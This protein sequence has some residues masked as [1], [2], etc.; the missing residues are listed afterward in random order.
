VAKDLQA[1]LCSKARLADLDVAQIFDRAAGFLER[2]G[3][4]LPK[5]A[6]DFALARMKDGPIAF[7]PSSDDLIMRRGAA[8]RHAA[9]WMGHPA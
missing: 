5:S 8:T 1:L 3:H 2:P 7:T 9:S 6:G 4:P